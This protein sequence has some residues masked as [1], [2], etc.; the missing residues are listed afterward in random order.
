[1][2]RALDASVFFNLGGALL[3]TFPES[4][5]QLAGLPTPV[6]AVYSLTIAFLVTLFAGAYFW[7]A[8]QPVIDRPLVTMLAIGKA[9]FFVVVLSC[10]LFGAA[11]TLSL[12]AAAGDLMFAGIFTWWLMGEPA[13]AAATLARAPSGNIAPPRG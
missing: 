5:G 3:F 4:I 11:S 13:P 2:R 8:R 6:P 10:W 9:G 7:L 12:G 1:M